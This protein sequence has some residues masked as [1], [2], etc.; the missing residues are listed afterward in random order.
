MRCE[1]LH[2][3][4]ELLA[5]PQ[6]IHPPLCR[7]GDVVPHVAYDSVESAANAGQTG[8]HIRRALPLALLE[9]EAD[10][11]KR[12]QDVIVQISK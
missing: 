6:G 5:K 11:I 2:E 8:R 3:V 9:L 10:G 7:T 1:R 12:L 4:R